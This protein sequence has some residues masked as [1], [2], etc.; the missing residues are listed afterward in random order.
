M[1]RTSRCAIV[2]SGHEERAG[3]LGRGQPAHRLQR[4]RHLRV[5]RERRVA[6]GE[7]QREPFVGQGVHVLLL[8]RLGAREQLGLPLE[9]PGA[10]DPVDRRV[11]RDGLDPGPR[12][13]R[14]PGP[15]PPLERRRERVLHRVLGELEVAEDADQGREDTASL[16]PEDALELVYPATSAGCST[17][18]RTSITP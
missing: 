17:T 18:G 8:G 16:V 2:A 4:Q 3:H 12:L 6:A 11:A 5:D 14:D 10:A 13:A 7:D 1:A 9:R 15:R